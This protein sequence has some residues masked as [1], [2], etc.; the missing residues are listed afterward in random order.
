VGVADPRAH[1]SPPTPLPS[2][3]SG[4]RRRSGPSDPR[5]L[6]PAG[7]E[8]VIEPLTGQSACWRRA[9]RSS[10]HRGGSTITRSPARRPSRRV[11]AGRTRAERRAEHAEHFR[12]PWGCT[13]GRRSRSELRPGSARLG[14]MRRGRLFRLFCSFRPWHKPLTS[15]RVLPGQG[16]ADSRPT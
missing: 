3:P 15:G 10:I 13:R 12:S 11:R 2:A 7:S 9:R 6:I 4:R 14:R 16:G 8:A 5:P 1:R